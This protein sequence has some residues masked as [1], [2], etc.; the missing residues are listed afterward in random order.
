MAMDRVIKVIKKRTCLLNRIKSNAIH[1]TL[2]IRHSQGIP[3]T[4][5]N[6]HKTFLIT[7]K[8]EGII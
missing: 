1:R 7:G 4:T 6:I 5:I 8:L 3:S 2:Q